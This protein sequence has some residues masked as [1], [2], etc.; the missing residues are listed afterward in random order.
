MN[1]DSTTAGGK[2]LIVEDDVGIART[3]LVS[4]KARG[5]DP[6]AV[7]TAARALAVAGEWLPDA[8]F[9]DLGLPDVSGLEVLRSLRRWSDVPVI[10]V[11]ARHDEAGKINALNEGADD[12]ITKPFSMG[13]LLA[14]L[15]ANLR[16][17]SSASHEEKPRIS[18]A[19][20]HLVVDLAKRQV[21]VG[22]R[23]VHVTPREWDILAY[24][25]QHH[26]ELV[27]K[28]ELLR[29]I[30]GDQYEKETNYLRVYISQLRRKIEPESAR[31]RYLRTE[32]GVG[33]RMVLD[34]DS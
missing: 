2:I 33:Y 10:V 23:L 3:L 9:L 6:K 1:A 21:F 11:S 28:L 30:W 32:V 5:Y 7:Q 24:L 26:G 25:V 8:V 17:S 27:T 13:E 19:D 16:R 12:Y 29:A 14:R 4:L 22:G 18:S 34:G 20:G 31:N 15:R